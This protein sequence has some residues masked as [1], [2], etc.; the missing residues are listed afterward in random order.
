MVEKEKR[1]KSKKAALAW[2][3]AVILLLAGL[4]VYCSLEAAMMSDILHRKNQVAGRVMSEVGDFISWKY[5]NKDFINEDYIIEGTCSG[6]DIVINESGSISAET[7][8]FPANYEG[9][10]FYHW[11]VRMSDGKAAEAWVFE[12]PMSD[13]RLKSYSRAEQEKQYKKLLFLGSRNT[14]GYYSSETGDNFSP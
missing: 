12:K 1:P 5:E 10:R 3:I 13:K 14:V 6:G 4:G 9:S 7:I 2:A 8:H 11:A